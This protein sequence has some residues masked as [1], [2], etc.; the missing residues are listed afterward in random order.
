MRG[1]PGTRLPHVL[2]ERDG[3]RVST[4]DLVGAGFALFAGPEGEA[5]AAAAREACAAAGVS[6]DVY[7]VGDAVRDPDGVLPEAF[8]IGPGGAVLVRPDA[9]WPGALALRPRA[10]AGLRSWRA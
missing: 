6:C 10:P 2:L 9:W 3:A 5:W 4:I 1:R 7:R 8:G